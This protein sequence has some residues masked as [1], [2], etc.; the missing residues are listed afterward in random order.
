[1]AN[2]VGE[3]YFLKRGAELG[4]TE[5][6]FVPSRKCMISFTIGSK[7]GGDLDMELAEAHQGIIS[8]LSTSTTNHYFHVM[9]KSPQNTNSVLGDDIASECVE[10]SHIP[11][12]LVNHARCP[13]CSRELCS[14]TLP[15]VPWKNQESL[16]QIAINDILDR[17]EVT[18]EREMISA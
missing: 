8:T 4:V 2:K 12:R 16:D 6:H 7:N 5:N 18:S 3:Q 10:A 15:L 13:F 11:N 1:M 14:N 17:C 9:Q